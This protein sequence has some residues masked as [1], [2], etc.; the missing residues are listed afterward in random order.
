MSKWLVNPD[1]AVEVLF[2][3]DVGNPQGG[4]DIYWPDEGQAQAKAN[5]ALIATAPELLEALQAC[6]DDGFLAGD[7]FNR[8]VT[9]IAKARGEL[10]PR[11]RSARS[12]RASKRK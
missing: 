10:R 9:A 3:D 7:V 2:F 4:A 11:R 8:A 1:N 6:L 5:A 12:T